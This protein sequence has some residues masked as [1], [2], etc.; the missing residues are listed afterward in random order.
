MIEL[1][2]KVQRAGAR[3]EFRRQAGDRRRRPCLQGGMEQRGRGLFFNRWIA[4]GSRSRVHRSGSDATWS[5][6]GHH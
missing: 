2:R 5:K 6:G 1:D 4:G 3:P